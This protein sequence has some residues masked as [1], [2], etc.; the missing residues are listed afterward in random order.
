MNQLTFNCANYVARQVGYSIPDA[1]MIA[2]WMRAD[3]AT[4]DWFSPLETFEER[5]AAVLD[6]VAATGLTA[7]DIWPAQLHANWATDEHIAIARRLLDERG[8]QAESVGGRFGETPEQFTRHCELASALGVRTLCGFTSVLDTDPDHVRTTLE[9][10]GLRL[11]LENHPEKTPEEVLA[12]IPD[13]MNGTLGVTVDTGWWGTQG[14]DAANAIEQLGDNVFYIHLKDVLA[15]G[16]HETCRYGDGIVPIER[17]V[18]A[19]RK[20]G[21]TGPLSIEHEPGDRDPVADVRYN[22]AR[23]EEWLA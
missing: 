21:Y 17:C 4:Q 13:G 19:A 22:R 5:Y 6:E 10:H 11:G 20:I 14:Y 12:K 18:D 23:L 7:I 1:E 2:N 16:A 15:E 8:L 3:A 9:R